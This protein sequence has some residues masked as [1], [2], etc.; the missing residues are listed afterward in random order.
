MSDVPQVPG[1]TAGW[2]P[3][4]PYLPPSGQMPGPAAS[5]WVGGPPSPAW[6]LA[7]EGPSR[8]RPLVISVLS[9]A[10]VAVVIAGV[11]VGLSGGSG[12]PAQSVLASAQNSAADK[13]ADVQLSIDVNGISSS[14]VTA[15]GTGSIDFSSGESQMTL[16]YSG[17]PGLSGTQLTEISTAD[18]L[19]VSVPGIST[20]LPGKSWVS[21]PISGSNSLTPGTTNPADIL[22]MLESQ[23]DTVQPLGPSTIGGD[24]VQ[25]YQVSINPSSINQRLGQSQLPANIQKAVGN[26]LGANG[27]HLDVYVGDANGLVREITLPLS[28]SAGG[29]SITAR[30]TVDLTHY[31]TPV[32]ITAPPPGEVATIQQWQA[33][34]GSQGGA[35]GLG[36]VVS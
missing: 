27:I 12:S 9:L 24:A 3:G 14:A 36:S 15:T 1:G 34:L 33:A 18:T 11:L 29:K 6:A 10:I 16:Q 2:Q 8:R 4:A 7:G 32:T 21:E 13:T 25:G 23:G 35:G 22:G 28:T 20:A 26:I 19:Y 17:L 31:G 5:G 30:V